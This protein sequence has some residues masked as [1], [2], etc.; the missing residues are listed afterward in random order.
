MKVDDLLSALPTREDIAAAMGLQLRASTTDLFSAFG[1]FSAGLLL[2][3][4][5]ALLFAPQPGDE[6]RRDI[7]EKVE[8]IGKRLGAN[9]RESST[10]AAGTA[11]GA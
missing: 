1:F 6:M 7:A 9:G 5:L 8:A 4:G 3:A 11:T 2:G 10:R